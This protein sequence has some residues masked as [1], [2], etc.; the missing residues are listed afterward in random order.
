MKNLFYNHEEPAIKNKRPTNA[1]LLFYQ[2]ENY[3][4]FLAAFFA[5]FFTVFFA[6]FLAAFFAFFAIAF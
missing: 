2:E 1:G 3:F 4:F 5:A 6:V